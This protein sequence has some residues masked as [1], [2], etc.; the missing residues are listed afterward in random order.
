[1]PWQNLCRGSSQLSGE[2]QDEQGQLVIFYE[3]VIELLT[4]M[5]NT[6]DVFSVYYVMLIS[7][8]KKPWPMKLIMVI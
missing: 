2:D 7:T 4:G 8:F 3:E 6:P 1:M 5:E